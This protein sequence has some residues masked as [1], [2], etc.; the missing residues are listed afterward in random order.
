VRRAGTDL[1]NQFALDDLEFLRRFA[2]HELLFY[3]ASCRPIGRRR[4]WWFSGSG[5]SHV[6]ESGVSFSA[7]AVFALGQLARRRKMPLLLAGTA[8]GGR[9]IDPLQT[10]GDA[11]AELLSASDLTPHPGLALEQVLAD[12]NT[13][14]REGEGGLPPSRTGAADAPRNLPSRTSCLRAEAGPPTRPFA[15]AVEL[16]ARSI[17]PKSGTAPR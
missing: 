6:G 12:R 9:A 14:Y 13:V 17:S 2:E 16:T 15:V 1:A 10:Q 11:L 5:R 3:R 4:I 7:A 8:N